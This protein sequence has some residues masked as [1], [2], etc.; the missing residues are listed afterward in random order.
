MPVEANIRRCR[1]SND[2]GGG[3]GWTEDLVLASTAS[4]GDEA[5]AG[6]SMADEELASVRGRASVRAAA[7]GRGGKPKKQKKNSIHCG[8][9]GCSSEDGF[10]EI[11]NTVTF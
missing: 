1:S 8:I 3:G 7:A 2:V 6:S 4:G 5:E 9:C 10:L 11:K